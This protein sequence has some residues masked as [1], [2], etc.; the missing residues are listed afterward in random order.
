MV[1]NYSSSPLISGSQL[2]NFDGLL[3][4]QESNNTDKKKEKKKLNPLQWLRHKILGAQGMTITDDG[5]VVGLNTDT[6]GI[7]NTD[8]LFNSTALGLNSAGL[9]LS[10]VYNAA[11]GTFANPLFTTDTNLLSTSPGFNIDTGKD[12]AKY[13]SKEMPYTVSL[14]NLFLTPEGKSAGLT[15]FFTNN[16]AIANLNPNN[17]ENG[18]GD[19][20]G[21]GK[22]KPQF[23]LPDMLGMPVKEYMQLSEEM[24]NRMANKAAFRASLKDAADSLYQGGRGVGEI[25]SAIGTQQVAAAQALKPADLLTQFKY[26]PYN[27]SLGRLLG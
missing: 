10:Q 9:D 14:E 11:P 25:G 3:L 23:N 27:S 17:K 19:G 4:A 26:M 24:A 20:D 8:G 15:G 1:A 6:K 7:V 2:G 18:N 12:L 13:F 16:S 22:D 21:N 5:Q